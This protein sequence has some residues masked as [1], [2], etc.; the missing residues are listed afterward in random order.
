[1][2]FIYKLLIAVINLCEWGRR[3]GDVGIELYD[4]HI[5]NL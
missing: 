3:G 5:A 4:S 1:M 2:C